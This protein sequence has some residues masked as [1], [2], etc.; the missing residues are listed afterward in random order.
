ML[1]HFRETAAIL[2]EGLE[3]DFASDEASRE[4]RLARNTNRQLLLLFREALHNSVRHA[5]CRSIMIRTALEQQIFTLEVRDDGCGIAEEKI[6]S[7]FC[8]RALKE[9]SRH[10]GGTLKVTSAPGQGTTILVRFPLTRTNSAK[11]S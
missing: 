11:P 4:C 9:R 3:W 1:G 2:L 7:P 8:L 5:R 6:A 10:L